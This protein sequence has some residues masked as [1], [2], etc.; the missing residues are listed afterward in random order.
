MLGRSLMMLA[1]LDAS[2]NKEQAYQESQY[3]DMTKAAYNADWEAST[4]VETG[5]PQVGYKYCHIWCLH[6]DDVGEIF[7]YFLANEKHD[8]L[9]IIGHVSPTIKFK[10]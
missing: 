5:W 1:V 7:I 6:K 9:K 4:I 2:A 10:E 8:F 3:P